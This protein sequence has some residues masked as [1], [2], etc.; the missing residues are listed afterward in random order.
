[1][2]AH[3]GVQDLKRRAVARP[4]GET[5]MSPTVLALREGRILAIVTTPRLKAT[6]ACA[7]T[8]AVGLD[9]ELLLVAAQ[10]ALADG[11]GI[12]Y[13]TMT[14]DRKAANALQRYEV[15]DG[16]VVFGP[17]VPCPPPSDRTIMDELARA[18]SQRP[19]D[20]ARVSRSRPE[21]DP[22]RVQRTDEVPSDGFLPAEEGRLALDAGTIIGTTQRVKGIAGTVLYVAA[23]PAHATRAVAHGLPLESLLGAPA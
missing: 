22:D 19:L 2:L 6:L 15:R 14:R 11:E 18:M 12:T 13:T 9:P 1:M 23:S 4:D 17:P 5:T 7:S 21:Q 8:L 16:E 10:V 3:P 20:P